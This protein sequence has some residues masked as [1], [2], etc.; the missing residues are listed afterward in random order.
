MDGDKAKIYGMTLAL[1]AVLLRVLLRSKAPLS[2]FDRRFVVA[3]L[4]CHGLFVY[5]LHFEVKKMVDAMHW[6]IYGALVAGVC[7][8]D[9]RL[10]GMCL[11]LLVA[12]QVLWE[13]EG[14]CLVNRVSNQPCLDGHTEALLELS[15]LVF[16]VAYA[17]RLLPFGGG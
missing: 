9:R 13:I 1:D 7:L 8:K 12:I 10:L 15:A 16:T 3:V 2:R 4:A 14:G 11:A 6:G 17:Y 5:G